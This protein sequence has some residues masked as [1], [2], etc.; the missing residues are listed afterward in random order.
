[1]L[2]VNELSI[3]VN[4]HSRYDDKLIS[5]ILKLKTRRRAINACVFV[6]C[7]HFKNII[8]IIY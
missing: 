7:N 3:I 1:M 5:V 2:V 6:M 4:K 8:I